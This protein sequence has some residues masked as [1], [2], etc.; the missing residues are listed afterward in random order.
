M[1]KYISLYI[2]IIFHWISS[3]F[4]PQITLKQFPNNPSEAVDSIL[5]QLSSARGMLPLRDNW[6]V[7]SAPDGPKIPDV[8]IP[9]TFDGEDVLFFETKFT[10][11]SEQNY[12]M[13]PELV[14]FGLFYQAE[15]YLNDYLIYKNSEGE[16]PFTVPLPDDLL[17]TD[18]ENK[19]T[20]KISST[21]DSESSI[22]LKQRF[23]FPAMRGGITRD[24]FIRFMP[25]I[26]LNKVK[27]TYK[28]QEN[29][30][31]VDCNINLRVDN[32]FQNKNDTSLAV[33]YSDLKMD[34]KLIAPDQSVVF[35]RSV[36][37]NNL[38]NTKFE[39]INVSQ[40]VK[41]ILPWKPASPDRYKLVATIS[42]GGKLID[43][44]ERSI[45]FLDIISASEGFF[46][47]GLPFELN[48]IT[49]FSVGSQSG[50]IITL[51]K[52]EK[53]LRLV[54]DIGFNT[55][56]FSKSLPHPAALNICEKIGLLPI[57]EIPLYDIPE[58]FTEKESFQIRS[59]NFLKILSDTYQ[60]FMTF[61]ILG[62]GGSYLPNSESHNQFLNQLAMNLK[63]ENGILVYASFINSIPENSGLDFYSLELF[64]SDLNS[65]S[66]SIKDIV[67][68]R[69]KNVI[70]GD[71]T[72]PTFNGGQTG[73]LNEYSYDAQAQ[74]FDDALNLTESENLGGYILNTLFDYGG[75]YPSFSAGYN[76]DN[77]YRL[78]LLGDDNSFSRSSYNLINSK[79]NNGKKVNIPVG[80]TSVDSPLIFILV[81]VFLSILMAVLIN[82]KRKFRE[83]A[84][85]AL[86]RPYNFFSDIRD[87]RILS[88]FHSNF[89]M[90]I[91]AGA[92]SLLFTI[93]LHYLKD[94]ILFEKILLSTGSATLMKIIGFLAWN[95]LY[96]LLYLFILSI[97]LMFT[98]T[99]LFIT[100][101]FFVKNRVLYSSIYYVAI[102]A[103]LP[104]ALLLPL[105]LILHRLLLL[106][107]VNIYLY[108]LIILFF[109]WL[110]QRLLK[111][112]YVIYDVNPGI[113]HTISAVLTVIIFGGI[114][115]YLQFSNSF[116]YYML[117][118]LK[119]FTIF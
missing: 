86:I 22:P 62:L 55:V 23:L 25:R 101:S 52:L 69:D 56:K 51:E 114:L 64:A 82:S 79:L 4:Y 44:T 31:D 46:I 113:L 99:I 71:I 93:I 65:E 41:N 111:G 63:S 77:I 15:L 18:E 13:R 11:T 66:N 57:L 76:K 116:I 70:L 98:I 48:G 87:H 28:F 49:Y 100:A 80:K 43:K 50:D 115:L 35:T 30:K 60:Q 5:Y 91:I 14:V 104:L 21:L 34:L 42:G 110:F 9:A 53:D 3:P 20:I 2:F 40:T 26:S 89:L 78:G 19:L 119:Q 74:Y 96:S 58:E 109:V 95:P 6:I 94:N 38:K 36:P 88:G 97:L 10:I 12:K 81:A 92:M 27:V 83:D 17:N 45:A 107:V 75:D 33:I 105:E 29:L 84:S 90:M 112:I 47:N 54:K 118:A 106:D 102:W 61:K 1:S 32:T 85:R 16:I 7:Y 8:Q 67:G 103:F 24:I 68:G 59:L 108:L 37:V 72:Y 117:N 39:D 73:Y